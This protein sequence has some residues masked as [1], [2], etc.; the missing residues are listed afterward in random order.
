[1]S[2][3]RWR[4]LRTTLRRLFRRNTQEA[5]MNAEMQFHFEQ[6]VDEFKDQGM[7]DRAARAAARRE[8]GSTDVYREEVRDS[9]RPPAISDLFQSVGFAFRS[10]R[11]SPGFSIL[12]I[13]TL[14]LGIGANTAMFSLVN[15]VVLKPIPYHNSEELDAIFRSTAQDPEGE[16]SLIEWKEIQE[17]RSGYDAIAGRMYFDASLAPAGE[18]PQLINAMAV[19][20][21][22]LG[23]LGVQ[24]MLGRSFRPGE[25]AAGQNR[26]L[27]LSHRFWQLNLGGRE[28]ILGLDVRI[29]GE[30]HEVVGVMP[31]SFGDW[32]LFGWLDILKPLDV[33]DPALQ[34]RQHRGMRLVG[35]RTAGVS[36]TEAAGLLASFSAD[37]E[38]RFPEENTGATWKHQ[39]LQDLAAGD[40]GKMVLAMLVGLSGF[41]VLICCSN[42][43]NFLL[44]R[45][46]ARAREF[47]VRSALGASRG[48]LLRPLLLESLLL[49]LGGGL[50]AIWV[51][52]GFSDWLQHSSTADNGD[53]VVIAIDQA[54]FAWTLGCS[55]LTAV[56]F[57]LAPSLFALR[58]NLNQTLKSGGRGST[59]SRGQQRLRQV[60]IIG[61]FAMAV[62]LLTGATLFMRGLDALN[63]NR[64]GWESD[65]LVTG[66]VF[67]PEGNYPDA[68]ARRQFH[69][70]AIAQ[71]GALAGA[72][73]VSL[74]RYHPFLQWWDQASFNVVGRPP[75]ELGREP[76]ALI[77]SVSND[78]FATVSTKIIAGRAFDSR[79]HAD[80]PA[81]IMVSE[82]LARTVFPDG[83][84]VGQ[85]LE[86]LESSETG[87][88]VEIVGVVE[89]VKSIYPEDHPVTFQVYQPIAQAPPALTEI[90]IR[91]AGLD[92]AA[93][94]PEIRTLIQGIDP[95]LPV[96]QLKPANDRIL[97][98]NYQLGVLRDLLS[99][100]AILG[101]VLAS[102]GIYG[103]IARLVAQ[104]YTEFGV[105]IALGATPQAI[106]RLVLVSGF[107]MVLW[108][109]ILGIA[110]SAG[111]AKLL[112]IGFPRMPHAPV[113]SIMLSLLVLLMVALAASLWPARRASAI[114]PC[115]ALRAE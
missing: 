12:A 81:R 91:T 39:S 75:A 35:R 47:A 67:L 32:R 101:L 36:D 64:E 21:N 93:L 51:A 57:S 15:A 80:A 105:R 7:D 59:G 40:N 28:D 29:N 88:V 6:L 94:V 31:P 113:V 96:T 58:L 90:A 53:Q 100:F 3:E 8:F 34:D 5:E 107:W 85:R 24:P 61:Q 27:I 45:T 33:N 19:T 50:C 115:E 30:P 11:R 114:D 46:M 83:P 104:R 4:W 79:D 52:H 60:L 73:S 43:A 10:L 17:T 22:F 44:A 65:N 69:D 87:A 70:Q 55:V 86:W 37:L 112:Q 103:V 111:L 99:S 42:L 1:M 95:D 92:P 49:S 2:G 84:A 78:Y 66:S 98:E 72:D 23:T 26:V 74:A 109:A 110:G 25:N 106:T 56:V 38:Q 48:Q 54:V 63:S 77:N 102:L 62:V 14:S 20:G 71:L 97:R 108:G 82:S 18:P 13:V 76:A 16:F 89:D 41:V 68:E 9:W